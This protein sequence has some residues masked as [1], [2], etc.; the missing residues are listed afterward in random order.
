M[1]FADSLPGFKAF[2]GQCVEECADF[3]HVVAFVSCILLPVVA[4]RSV[5]AAAR[6]LRSDLRNAGNLLRFLGGSDSPAVL[7]A[8]AQ[9]RLLEQAHLRDRRLHLLVLDST[10]HGH[11]SPHSENSYAC[12]NTT[13]RPARSN[14]KQK[15]TAPRSCHCFVFALLLCP[16][17]TR[18]P[19]WLPFYTQEYCQIRGWRHQT[20]AD[21]AAQLITQLPLADNIP[22]VVVG[23]T[24]FEAKQIRAAC[25][26]RDYRWVVP[27]NPERRLATAK[28]RPTVLSLAQ[29]LQPHD[30]QQTSLRL[31][32][33]ELAPL[34][35]V[36]RARSQSHKPHRVYWVHRRIADVLSIGEVVLLFSNQKVPSVDVKGVIKVQKVLLS[37]ALQAS[38]AELLHWYALRWQIELFFKEMK[39]QLGLSQ[40]QVRD[41]ARVV[42]WVNLC[43]LSFCYLEQRRRELLEQSQAEERRHWE[44]AR[45]Q[46]LRAW[47]REEVEKADLLHL[48]SQAKDRAGRKRLNALIAAGY[49]GTPCQLK[50]RKTA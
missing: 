7:L 4:R 23:D 29:H 39:S 21:L 11:Q 9:Q 24:A 45:A 6:A 18:I 16:D 3:G 25:A 34:A 49:D 36:S 1:I 30:F 44:T 35:R 8:A 19:Y 41:F 26:Q 48:L 38:A 46:G 2:L 13:R 10:L 37:N 15:Q 47:L 27:I 17:G 43:V 31:D 14:R 42:S 28:P 12:R 5:Q 33:G 40:Y 20:Q 32:Q 50:R 22:V